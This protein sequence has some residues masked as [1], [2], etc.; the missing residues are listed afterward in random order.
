[1]VASGFNQVWTG[2]REELRSGQGLMV[3]LYRAIFRTAS[4]PP[5]SQ[6]PH[7]HPTR[8]ALPLS[9]PYFSPAMPANPARW[10]LWSS[11]PAHTKLSR[12]PL[13]LTHLNLLSSSCRMAV[14]VLPDHAHSLSP[15]R[16]VI[17]WW[18]DKSNQSQKEM[19]RP[20][21]SPSPLLS[22]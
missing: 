18:K 16:A 15:G 14:R 2:S 20:L 9:A 17:E 11:F 4:H 5:C 8:K 1:M 6:P 19:L 12:V 21:Q 3:R 7:P 13:G 22:L 10:S